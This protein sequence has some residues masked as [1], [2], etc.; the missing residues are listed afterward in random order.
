MTKLAGRVRSL[1]P[2]PVFYRATAFTYRLRSERRL[3]F[4][5][6]FVPSEGTAVDAGAWWGPW[7][8]WLSR[9]AASVWAFEPNPELASFLTRVAS[10]NVHV[11][12]VALSDRASTGTLFAPEDVGRD[13]LATLSAAHSDSGFRRIE[14]PLQRLDDYRLEE[15]KFMKI[16]VEGHEFEVLA[17]AEE[18]LARCAPTLLVEVDQAFHDEPIQRIFSWL[19]ARGYEGRI[20]RDRIWAPLSAFDVEKDQLLSRNVRSPRYI[21]DF[22][23]TPRRTRT[24]PSTRRIDRGHSDR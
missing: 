24:H 21:N 3:L 18:T 17:G 5:D 9:R 12:N 6:E 23:F 11:E 4:L 14:V 20:R 10:P 19:L 16:D 7:T 13:A 22:V 1:L 2:D 15:V 8:Y